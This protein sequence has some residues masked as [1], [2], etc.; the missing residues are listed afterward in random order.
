[1]DP[2]TGSTAVATPPAPPAAPA[3]P[4]AVP[5]APPAVDRAADSSTASQ[6]SVG[7]RQLREQY[8]GLKS[9]YEPW[10]KLGAK[11]EEVSSRLPIIQKMWTEALDL[12]QKLGY[13]QKEVEDFLGKD[14]VQVLAY[15]RQQAQTRESQP[16]DAK[17]IK[18]ELD[19]M[20]SERLK[21]IT[22]R[23]NDRMNKEAEFRFEGEFDRLY[24]DN[25]KDGL[26]DEAKEALYEMVGQLVGEDDEAIKRLKFEG[27]L[28][29]VAKH[30]E[31]AKTRLLKVVTAMSAHERKRAGLNPP[32]PGTPPEKPAS[33]LDAKLSG[34]YTVRELMA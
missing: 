7:L 24:K 11:P 13:D 2:V 4:P 17:T 8:E 15:L 27:K 29:D 31:T 20:V 23:E 16:L 3:T 9:K 21:P 5:A 1:M 10:E 30:F 32:A 33:K 6:D 12:G 26:P 28:S 18:S 14:P 25:F 19:R 34:G 22:E